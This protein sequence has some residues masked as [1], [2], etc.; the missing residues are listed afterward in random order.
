MKIFLPE[1]ES[2]D[3]EFGQLTKCAGIH[4]RNKDSHARPGA[5]IDR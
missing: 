2:I 5:Q 3:L 1:E 4:K